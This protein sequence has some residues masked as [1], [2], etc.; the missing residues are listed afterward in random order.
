MSNQAKVIFK[1][2]LLFLVIDLNS[3]MQYVCSIY[4]K[5]KLND[6]K[7][8]VGDNVHYQAT[9]YGYVIDTIKTRKNLLIRPKLANI[10][11]V[12]LVLSV[13]NPEFSSYLLN[14]FIAF[15]QA[16]N[17]DKTI[18][19]FSKMDL[20][21]KTQTNYFLDLISEYQ[22]NNFVVLNSNQK[23]KAKQTILKMMENNTI[24]F[25][26]QS[27][28]GKSTFI[29]YLFPN[30]GLKTNEISQKLK[31]G[32]NTTTSSIAIPY[33]NGFIID[34]PGFNKLDLNL[35]RK[36]LASAY[37]DFRENNVHCKF[38][39]CLHFNEQGC[40]IKKMVSENKIYL[41]RYQ[42]YL[43]ILKEINK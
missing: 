13:S 6:Q 17:I 32:K 41:Q 7:I 38:N 11:I 1:T 28:V 27:G 42:D 4:K 35:T 29:N 2:A 37:D 34:T 24:C 12:C 33:K 14:K 3:Q 5:T 16:R 18:I 23:A 22:K 30:L 19:Y 36:E 25:A 21:D 15:Y 39:D 26:G 31:R 20:L 9:Q 10:N 8:C 40:Y 43:K